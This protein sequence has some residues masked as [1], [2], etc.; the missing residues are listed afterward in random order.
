M[1]DQTDFG[2]SVGEV[3][4]EVKVEAEVEGK[5]GGNDAK[6]VEAEA[7]K[8]AEQAERA[9]RDIDAFLAK[10]EWFFGQRGRGPVEGKLSAYERLKG[11]GRGGE[12]EEVKN[13]L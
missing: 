11:W 9:H 4:V 8:E 10:Y 2:H 6:K 5:E 7:E 13:F 12:E 1:L 3:E